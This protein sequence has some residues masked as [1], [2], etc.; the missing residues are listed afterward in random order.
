M[1]WG[2]PTPVFLQIHVA[3]S[4]V[5]IL[6]GIVA[7]CG[8]VT[9]RHLAGWTA[10]FLATTFLTGVTGFPLPPFGLDPPRIVG[11]I[12][13]CALLAAGMALYAFGLRGTAR[14]VYVAG[15]VFSLYLNVFVAIAQSFQKIGPLHALAPTQSEPPFAIA[16]G[17]ALVAFVVFG[18]LAWRR[19]QSPFTP[20]PAAA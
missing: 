10:I 1:T 3:L 6:T 11:I 7:L 4:L 16:Q 2:I 20:T 5:G 8:M 14:S 15:A 13:I 19:F 12:L 9:G 17:A 18:V